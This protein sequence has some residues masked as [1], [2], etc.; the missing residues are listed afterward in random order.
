MR[1]IVYEARPD[2][3]LYLKAEARRCECDVIISSEVP[4]PDNAALSEGCDGV[5]ILGQ[6]SIDENLLHNWY[7]NGV[8]YLSTRTIGSNHIDLAAA[9]R[10]G[11]RVCNAA[12]APNG[13]ADFA[14]MLMLMCIRHYK[15]ALW[16]GQVNDFELN[17]LQG[18][19]LRS[20]TVGIVGT[21]RI[22][23]QTARNLSGFGCR[24]IAYDPNPNNDCSSL[25]YVSLEELYRE[26]DIITLHVPLTEQ[27]YHMINS[28]SLNMMK[29]GVILINCARG[30][31]C[32][33]EALIEGVESKKIGAL[34]IDTTEG[35]EGIIHADHRIDILRGRDWFYLRQFRNVVMTP[36]MAFYTDEAIESIVRCGIE[37]I[38]TMA[39][40]R[41]YITEL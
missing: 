21:G 2:E 30:S 13:V 22:G 32:D 19:E 9:K 4:S 5:S 27:N 20:M 23:M 33:I 29:D 15:Q 16:R 10:I 38:C 41:A 36:H 24:L 37:G 39:S 14:V 25:D 11:I 7:E 1:I 28:E 34:G 6:G 12:Y 40:G 31:L 17:G 18:R 26:S 35:E 3:E 8:R